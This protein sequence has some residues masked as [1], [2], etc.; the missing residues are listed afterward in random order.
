MADDLEDRKNDMWNMDE[1][2]STGASSETSDNVDSSD[3]SDGSEV[4]ESEED[5]SDISNISDTFDTFAEG[6]TVREL[7]IDAE[8]K[9]LAVRDLHNVNV[10]LYESIYRDMVAKFKELDAEYFQQHGDELS[11]NKEFFNAVFRA[12][13]QSPQLREELELEE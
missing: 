5:N 4:D 3:T 8:A 9:Q 2:R 12:G 11:K 7:A 1:V 10:Y 6:S 13:L